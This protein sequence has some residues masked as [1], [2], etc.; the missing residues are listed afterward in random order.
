MGVYE[1]WRHGGFLFVGMYKNRLGNGHVYRYDGKSW[2]KVGGDGIRGS[3]INKDMYLV[4]AFAS[5]Q[6]RLIASLTRYPAVPGSFSSVW[7]FDGDNWKP[8]ELADE[9]KS[10]QRIH[11]Y[12]RHISLQRAF[13]LALGVI[14][15]LMAKQ[16][17]GSYPMAMF[18]CRLV[19]MEYL[20]HGPRKDR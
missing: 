16:G 15:M 12:N 3:W 7:A 17:F 20:D 2:E 10:L 8:I 13:V 1:I 11:N 4:E 9:Q 5:Y 18:G 19:A 14:L 6:G